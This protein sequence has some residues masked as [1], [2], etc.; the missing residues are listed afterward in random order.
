MPEVFPL[1]LPAGV[2]DPD[3]EAFLDRLLRRPKP[4]EEIPDATELVSVLD[5]WSGDATAAMFSPQPA[6]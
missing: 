2:P 3:L 6:R 5:A 4:A 1:G